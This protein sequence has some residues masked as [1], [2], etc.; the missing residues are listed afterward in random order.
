M[1]VEDYFQK[2][3]NIPSNINKYNLLLLHFTYHII[4]MIYGRKLSEIIFEKT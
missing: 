4:I 2:Q 1:L 3:A